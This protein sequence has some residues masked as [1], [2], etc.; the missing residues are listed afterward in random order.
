[1]YVAPPQKII[2]FSSVDKPNSD[3]AFVILFVS[4]CL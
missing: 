4:R 3:I 1:L 2:L